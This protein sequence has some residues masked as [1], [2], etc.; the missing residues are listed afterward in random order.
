MP[1]GG[2]EPPPL[3]KGDYDLNVAC[4]PISPPWQTNLMSNY[5]Y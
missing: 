3:V 2:V 5:R 4:L 1:G